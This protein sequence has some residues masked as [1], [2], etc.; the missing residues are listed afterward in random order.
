MI[1]LTLK[2]DEM[3]RALEAYARKLET[4]A[5]VAV[6]DASEA[7]QASAVSTIHATTT[8][9]TGQLEDSW[10]HIWRGPFQRLLRNTSNHAGF[11]DGGTRPHFI[12]ARRATFLRFQ[13]NGVT[14][15]RRSVNHPGTRPRP[16]V[17]L[18]AA[19]GQMALKASAQ[20]GIDRIASEF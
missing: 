11:I 8:R 10:I 4:V 2:V 12:A 16:F 6:M 14:M 5:R 17:A 9:R 18:S 19:V 3:K 15:F 1:G 7:A 20:S 13:M